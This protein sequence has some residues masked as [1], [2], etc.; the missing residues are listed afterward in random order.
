MRR[1]FKCPDISMG[2][3]E[4]PDYK[5]MVGHLKAYFFKGE[6]KSW[7]QHGIAPGFR[8]SIPERLIAIWREAMIECRRN[9]FVNP[10]I[11]YGKIVFDQVVSVGTTDSADLCT[12]CNRECWIRDEVSSGEFKRR[13]LATPGYQ[14]KKP[15]WANDRQP[16]EE[17]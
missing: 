7:D 9:G 8:D 14:E 16:G 17:G 4:N 10:H 13:R 2:L 5:S 1:I 15:C 11:R 6:S 12:M 3:E